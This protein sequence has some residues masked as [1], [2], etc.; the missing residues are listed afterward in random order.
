M[1]Y[2]DLH[3]H[4]TMSDG[5]YS[6]KGLVS[7][8]ALRGL[9]AIAITDHDTISGIEE[10]RAVE[11]YYGVKVIS[12]VE[13]SCEHMDSEVHLLGYFLESADEELKQILA[14]QRRRRIARMEQMIDKMRNAG[15]SIQLEDVF[16][17]AK[18]GVIGRPHLASE[19]LA[20]GY[21]DNLKTAYQ[22]YIAPGR[23]FY[24]PPMRLELSRAVSMLH[25]S[26]AVAILAHPVFLP[27]QVFRNI[28]ENIHIDGIEVYYPEHSASFQEMLLSICMEKGLS[29]TG[30]SDFHGE[31]KAFD[32]FGKIGMSEKLFEDM[33][34]RYAGV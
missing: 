29:I 3:T 17:R 13:L 10:A 24:V 20:K 16:R 6:P 18:G 23:P 32:S 1:V 19:L 15:F 14:I 7:L 26:G 9:K 27:S 11:D 34:E 33:I 22:K 31:R 21:I 5:T 12:G 8:A 4:T 30:G 25:N 28:I 2:A